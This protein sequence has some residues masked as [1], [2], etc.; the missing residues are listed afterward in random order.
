MAY[1]RRYASII[2]MIWMAGPHAGHEWHLALRHRY[3][4]L[5]RGRRPKTNAPW[6]NDMAIAYRRG[7]GRLE[8]YVG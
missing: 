1:L 3:P 6:L 5:P 4:W 7:L 2:R 8:P